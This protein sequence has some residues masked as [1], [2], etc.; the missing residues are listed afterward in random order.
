M[1]PET[2]FKQKVL[3]RLKAIPD[4]YFIKIQQMALRG[5][6][7]ILICYKGHFIAFELK[8]PPNKVKGGSLQWLNIELIRKAGGIAKEVT[9][10]NFEESLKELL[11]LNG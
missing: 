6:P 3:A 10:D 8:I 2:R 9:P 7:D 11:C 4:I 1:Q 5:H